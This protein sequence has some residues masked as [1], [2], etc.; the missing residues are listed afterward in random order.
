M[1]R[2]VLFHMLEPNE[3]INIPLL[4]CWKGQSSIPKQFILCGIS[5][6]TMPI[7]MF[8]TAKLCTEVIFATR[9]RCF[10]LSGFLG[11]LRTV[12][13]GAV[14]VEAATTAIAKVV[15]GGSGLKT[16]PGWL[17]M[18]PPRKSQKHHENVEGIR[19]KFWS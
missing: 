17:I 19:P 7:F 12:G 2:F 1:Y 13:E 18:C 3:L 9:F 11:K 10:L 4:R 14:I 5:T 15:D 6:D 8:Q 16:S